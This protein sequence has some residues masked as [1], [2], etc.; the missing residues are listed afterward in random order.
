MRE[1]HYESEL[2]QV[3]RGVFVYE[4]V[5]DNW[6]AHFKYCVAGAAAVARVVALNADD[7]VP[8]DRL[9][10]AELAW[11]RRTIRKD[12]HGVRR[13]SPGRGE[14]LRAPHALW[15]GLPPTVVFLYT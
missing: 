9:G 11:H 2:G 10:L 14:L 1:G 13:H 6:S 5:G 8:R 15:V 3:V 7:A 4:S 12:A